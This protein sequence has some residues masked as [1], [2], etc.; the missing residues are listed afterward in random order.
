MSDASFSRPG[1]VDLSG[2]R[3][4]P[5][6]SGTPGASG[7]F[8]FDVTSEQVLAAEV[9]NRSMSVPV[10]VSFW[11]TRSAPSQ[12]I[13]DTLEVLA[14]EFAGR[15]VLARVDA[16]ALAE[17]VAALRIPGVP[18]VAVALAGQLAPLLQEPVP[19]AQMR[20]LLQQVLD[21][22]VANGVAGRAEPLRPATPDTESVADAGPRH[23]EAEKALLAGDSAAAIA[24][25]SKAVSDDPADAEARVGLAR[26]QLL[27]RTSG[28]DVVAA[29]TAAADRPTDVTAGVLV[30]DLDLL[31]GHV[32][33]AFARLVELVRVTSGADRDDARRH[34]LELFEAVG[35]D[36]PRVGK[37]RQ[38]LT[39]ALF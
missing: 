12:Q 10:V 1:A 11:S 8:A 36:D 31:G 32:E 27:E 21:A 23:P 4:A 28:V 15:F 25:Y 22:A 2:L 39:S 20:A 34:L 13:N 16:D 37:A 18:L 19:L 35:S 5:T 29:R 3:V 26:A 30:A 6:D 7:A 9:V 17:L 33:D 14:D 24:A 38:A